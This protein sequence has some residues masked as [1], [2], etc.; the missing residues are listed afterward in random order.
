MSSL[1][2]KDLGPYHIEEQIGSGGMAT[3]YKAHHAATDRVS[4]Q[5]FGENTPPRRGLEQV[6]PSY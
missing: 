2:D 5:Y 4:S 3:V 1:I 6:S